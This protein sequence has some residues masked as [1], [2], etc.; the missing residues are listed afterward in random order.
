MAMIKLIIKLISREDLINRLTQGF[1]QH[2]R[3]KNSSIN[4]YGSS[5]NGFGTDSSDMDLCLVD[6]SIKVEEVLDLA[7]EVCSI[8]EEMKMNDV[9]KSRLHARIPVIRFDDP[10]TGIECDLCFNNVLPI[11]NT[12]LLKTYSFI[13]KI[14]AHREEV[15]TA[16]AAKKLRELGIIHM[17][18]VA[19]GGVFYSR[20]R[21]WGRG[22]YGTCGRLC[23]GN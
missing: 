6:S 13:D 12:F 4:I 19:E 8:L 2:E 22:G 15:L 1:H 20:Y 14:F 3:F 21:Q 5:N 23:G 11:R 7:D 16:D 17:H 9:D 10:I 18:D